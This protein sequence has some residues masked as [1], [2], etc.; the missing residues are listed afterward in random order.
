MSMMLA[1]GEN[2]PITAPVLATA[3]GNSGCGAQLMSIL[4]ATDT[5]IT[6]TEAVLIAAVGNVRCG[7]ELISMLLAY[8]LNISIPESVLVAVAG[9]QAIRHRSDVDALGCSYEYPNN[10]GS[11]DGRS[12][13]LLL[14]PQDNV[15]AVGYR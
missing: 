2:D 13:E 1:A 10:C 8:D 9:N 5:R 14:R 11:A 12:G 15:N 4:L 6:I 7:L 3:A